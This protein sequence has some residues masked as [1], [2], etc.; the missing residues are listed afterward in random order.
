MDQ[1]IILILLAYVKYTITL[2]STVVFHIV[3]FFSLMY[4]MGVLCLFFQMYFL[5][6]LNSSL[7]ISSLIVPS[8]NIWTSC[9]MS[10]C[11]KAPWIKVPMNYLPYLASIVHDNIMASRDMV[12]PFV[13]QSFCDLT[14]A[15]PLTL[16]LPSHFSFGKIRYHGAF[17]FSSCDMSSLL[18][19]VVLLA[20]EADLAP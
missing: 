13:M 5:Y 14:L 12:S 18:R 10:A 2:R 20:D 15:H 19:A 7:T 4:N 16:M 8:N 9:S 3:P 6:D 17:F 1:L 11:R